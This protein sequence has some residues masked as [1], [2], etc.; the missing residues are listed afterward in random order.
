KGLLP[1]L[2]AKRLFPGSA[3][4]VEWFYIAV[5]LAAILGHI[6]T[7]YLRFKGG[8]GVATASGAMLALAPIPLSAA[9]LAFVFVF[10]LTR[11]V[12]LGS[13]TAALVF[14]VAV[15]VERIIL[16]QNPMVPVLA[17][18]WLLFLLVIVTHKANIVRLV[19]GTEN[20]ISFK[21]KSNV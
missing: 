20:R 6:F 9:L 7:P 2:L 15:A 8:K 1:V 12:S 3:F 17:V 19:Q 4:T 11:Y 13:L 10:V 14:P 21:Y 16:H 5:A 18:G